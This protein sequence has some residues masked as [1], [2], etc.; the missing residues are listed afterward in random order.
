ME[1]I[2]Q[3]L[4]SSRTLGHPP[5]PP[6]SKGGGTTSDTVEQHRGGTPYTDVSKEFRTR[7]TMSQGNNMQ[8]TEFTKE[9]ELENTEDKIP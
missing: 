5:P 7:R 8:K 9:E 3:S 4:W 6:P 1:A 2:C